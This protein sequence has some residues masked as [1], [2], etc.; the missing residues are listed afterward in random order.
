[1]GHS[2]GVGEA[3]PNA[4]LIGAAQSR[5]TNRSGSGMGNG[6]A[7]IAPPRITRPDGAAVQVIAG[8]P[9]TVRAGYAFS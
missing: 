9:E 2:G 6:V 4:G 7:P 8:G 3:R 1:M 5:V